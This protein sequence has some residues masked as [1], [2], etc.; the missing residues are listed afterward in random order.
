MLENAAPLNDELSRLK[1]EKTQQNIFNLQ[2]QRIE[3]HE[4]NVNKVQ[5]AIQG[6]NR[7]EDVGFGCDQRFSSALAP[8]KIE[9]AV[10]IAAD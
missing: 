10:K 4:K 8:M 2:S 7:D 9:A 1:D 3:Q 5:T 6:W